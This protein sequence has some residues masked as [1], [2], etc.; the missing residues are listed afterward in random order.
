MLGPHS[1]TTPRV[2]LGVTPLG[3]S[4][5]FFGRR[6]GVT[7]GGIRK[8]PGLGR[9]FGPGSRR[10]LGIS[11]PPAQFDEMATAIVASVHLCNLKMTCFISSRRR[12]YP[13]H[14]FTTHLPGP[15]KALATHRPSHRLERAALSQFP[16]V[17]PQR[18]QGLNLSHDTLP[19][20]R[21]APTLA[22]SVARLGLLR[23]PHPHRDPCVHTSAYA[24]SPRI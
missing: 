8:T 3:G 2:T 20:V 19:H 1:K 22:C 10:H 18:A 13:L 7:L 16:R 14:P 24:L 17:N 21:W 12:F 9:F 11:K 15:S 5:P 4:N 6:D 23:S